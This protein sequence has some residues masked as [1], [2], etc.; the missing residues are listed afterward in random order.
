MISGETHGFLTRL[1]GISGEFGRYSFLNN[2]RINA[3]YHCDPEQCCEI[4]MA[5]DLVLENL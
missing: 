1:L 4:L 2:K 3:V 5:L